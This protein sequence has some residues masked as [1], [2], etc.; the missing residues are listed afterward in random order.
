MA[1][2]ADAARQ[3]ADVKASFE[4]GIREHLSVLSRLL[5]KADN[6]EKRDKAMAILSTMVGALTL[7]RVVND[8]ASLNLSWMRQPRAFAKP[9]PRK[10]ADFLRR[11][12]MK[13][14][15]LRA[16]A[17]KRRSY[18]RQPAIEPNR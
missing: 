1:L 9:P 8:P 2:G 3:S 14:A 6:E 11:R 12:Y 18:A 5:S 13:P 17:R 16:R 7:S 15:A 10:S 4:A